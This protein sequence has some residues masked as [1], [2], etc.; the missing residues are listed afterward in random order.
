MLR[1]GF[2]WQI[3]YY[4]ISKEETFH[5]HFL[6]ILK[7]SFQNLQI[8]NH[9]CFRLT[10]YIRLV[11]SDNKHFL[12]III[13]IYIAFYFGV[14]Q[15]VN[16]IFRKSLFIMNHLFIFPRSSLEKYVRKTS[17]FAYKVES[18]AYMRTLNWTLATGKSLIWIRHTISPNIFPCG[19]RYEWTTY[20]IWTH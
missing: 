9:N 4:D 18:S 19:R 8:F 11:T 7:H 2:W 6:T 14:T 20:K 1:R 3:P 12:I 5:Q 16:F 15:R 13:H 10:P 17:K